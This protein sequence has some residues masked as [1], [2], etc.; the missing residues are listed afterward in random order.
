M[1]ALPCALAPKSNLMNKEMLSLARSL[2]IQFDRNK[3]RKEKKGFR[4]VSV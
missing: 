4:T 3:Q 2:L 1:L